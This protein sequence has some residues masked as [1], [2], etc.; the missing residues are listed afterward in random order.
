[1]V[2]LLL[3]T[4]SAVCRQTGMPSGALGPKYTSTGPRSHLGRHIPALGPLLHDSR[5]PFSNF[6]IRYTTGSRPKSATRAETRAETGPQ[7]QRPGSS[8][9]IL[10]LD[11]SIFFLYN[12]LFI[13]SIRAPRT[14]LKAMA[15]MNSPRTLPFRMYNAVVRV[16]TARYSPRQRIAADLLSRD[17]RSSLTLR[18]EVVPSLSQKEQEFGE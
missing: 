6:A 3:P 8:T 5:N 10:R 12:A 7:G 15:T 16:P 4:C 1:M 9:A 11:R 13:A 14:S 2:A 17:R 18:Q